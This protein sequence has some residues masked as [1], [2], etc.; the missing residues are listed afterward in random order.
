MSMSSR[1]HERIEEL[2]VADVLNGLDQEDRSE[3]ERILDEHG[4]D[5]QTCIELFARYGDVAA[6]LAITL[7]PIPLTE[8][9]EDRLVTAARAAPRD[10]AGSQPRRRSLRMVATL[11]AAAL[12]AGI[13]GVVGFSLAP[14]APA[15]QAAFLAFVARPGTRI[16]GFSTSQGTL[17]VAYRPG[18]SNGWIVGADLRKPAGGQTYELWSSPPGDDGVRPAGTFLPI[19][20]TVIEPAHLGT[21]FDLLAVSI[22]P[23]GGSAQPTTK[24]ILVLTL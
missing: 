14:R 10:H 5:C 6:G 11:A 19:H 4:P 17:A 16:V 15:G 8:G 21:A 22:E 1:S 9:A 13:A 3:L 7:D 18:E 23:P 24:P 2:I 20:G 12:I